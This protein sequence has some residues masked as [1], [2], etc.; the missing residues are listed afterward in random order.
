MHPYADAP[1]LP[2][3]EPIDIRTLVQ[4]ELG[5]LEIEI[6]PGRGGFMLERLA[7]RLDVGMIGFEIKRKW[8][9]IVEDRLARAGFAERGHVFAEDAG[10]ALPRLG[11]DGS[12]SAVFLNFPDP[13][14]KKRHQKRLVLKP[15]LLDE[16]ARLLRP[17]GELFLQTDVDER[18]RQYDAQV[19]GHGAF[20]PSGDEPGSAWLAD[21][22]YLATSHRERRAMKDVIPVYRLRFARRAVLPPVSE[23]TAR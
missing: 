7:A 2:P 23:G 4:R 14:W 19:A 3:G 16:I 5:D 18:A 13:W 11:P 8:A 22:P 12:V 17:G 20:E 15:S 10:A 21:N 9:W 6:G 1:L